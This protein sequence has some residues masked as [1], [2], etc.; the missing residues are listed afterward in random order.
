MIKITEELINSVAPNDSAIK[1]ALGLIKKNSFIKLFK[2]VDETIIFGE[3]AGSGKSNYIASADFISSENPVF[4]CTCPSRQ[5][6]CK[7][8]IALMYAY[9]NG[10]DFQVAEIPEDVLSKREKI[11]KK[12]TKKKE[13]VKT[14]A[15]KKVNKSAL[16]KKIKTQIEG[17]EL[18]EKITNDIIRSGF[19]SLD[20][21]ALKIL[22][23]G[24]KQLGNYFLPGVQADLKRLILYFSKNDKKEEIYNAALNQTIKLNSLAKKGKEYLTKRLEDPELTMDSKSNIEELLGHVWLIDELR[25]AKLVQENVELIQ[26]YFTS[27]SDFARSEDIDLGLWINMNTGKLNTTIN[28]R[29]FKAKK[30]IREDD[31]FFS[32]LGAKELY[33]YPGE[34][35]NARVRWEEMT[36]RDINNKDFIDIKNFAKKS[37]DEVIKEVKKQVKNPLSNKNPEVLIAY[38]KLGKIEDKFVVEDETGKKIVIQNSFNNTGRSTCDL[39]GLLNPEVFSKGA[40]LVRFEFNLDTGKI[41]A[42]PLSIITDNEIIRLVY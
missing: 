34:D 8:S 17:L 39:L 1:N 37:Y 11:E 13:A 33:V 27:F 2:A 41:Y 19:A 23:G 5:I 4:R 14:G 40:M 42:E 31:S 20:V 6:P 24:A 21:K 28:Y 25:S 29:P 38:S 9:L 22:E 10:K 32:V 3:C 18:A 16:S 30:Y 26:L 15:K 35:M 7:H 12:E 36:I